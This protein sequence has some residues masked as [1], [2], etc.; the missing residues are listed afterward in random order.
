MSVIAIANHKGGVGKTTTTVNLA[1]GLGRQG[2]KVLVID[3]DPQSN[4]TFSL[5]LKKQD[6]TI[7]QV[8]AFQDDIRKMIQPVAGVDLVPASVH[9][10]GFEKNNE[11]GKEFILQESLDPI[12][13][14][15]DF[16]LIDCPPSL[17]ALT[18]SA[19]TAS[20]FVI[21]ALQ[22]EFLALQGMT[23][24]I[25]I[26]RT[27]KTRMNSNLELLGIVVTQFDNRKV[28]HR[29]IMEHARNEYGDAVFD[30]LIRGN[31]A[32]A[33]CQSM[34]KH[35]FDYDENCNGAEDY[36]LLALEVSQRLQTEL[37]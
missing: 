31:I 11:V 20:D 4:A 3:L 18:I 33:E 30:T 15:Y 2:H 28:L 16:I 1:A 21:I 6:R 12:R 17:G 13:S 7:Y 9:L 27:V 29:D 23:D 25:K 24:F 22:P 32:L 8:L 19:L 26:L 10:A 34:G 37:V 36:S 5:G 35:I 14:E